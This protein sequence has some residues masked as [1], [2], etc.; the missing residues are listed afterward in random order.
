M[1]LLPLYR[2]VNHYIAELR[3]VLLQKFVLV[4]INLIALRVRVI[5]VFFLQNIV[6]DIL[7]YKFCI[8]KYRRFII[9]F[10]FTCYYCLITL[11]HKVDFLL[12][13]PNIF[14]IN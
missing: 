13:I 1:Q 8:Y 9:A 6:L 2:H 10:V 5:N 3:I 12:A 14:L 7:H 4:V 11:L